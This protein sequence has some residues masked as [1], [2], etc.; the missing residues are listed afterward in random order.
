MASMDG[1]P[2]YVENIY[3]ENNILSSQLEKLQ[4]SLLSRNLVLILAC[5][6]NS[7]QS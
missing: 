6:I 3:I 2:A 7:N 4:T 1:F 5:L